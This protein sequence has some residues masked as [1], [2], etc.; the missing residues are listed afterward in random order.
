MPVKILPLSEKE[1]NEFLATPGIRIQTRHVVPESDPAR[2]A[3][4]LIFYE[5]A[6]SDEALRAR[7]T[8]DQDDQLNRLLA[9]AKEVKG[10]EN[11]A[12]L[13]NSTQK[14]LFLLAK[15]NLPASDADI[16]IEILRP[17]MAVLFFG[18]KE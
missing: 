5:T 2:S 4:V 10:D 3:Q 15:H 13:K 16:V 17:E 12:G 7:A 11:Y 14:R 9:I 18:K 6:E 8:I 1:I